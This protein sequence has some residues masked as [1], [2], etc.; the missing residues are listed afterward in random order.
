[1]TTLLYPGLHLVPG[2]VHNT[3]IPK[4]GRI[5]LWGGGGIKVQ[6]VKKALHFYVIISVLLYFCSNY[7]PHKTNIK[8]KY[9]VHLIFWHK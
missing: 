2:V 6:R 8:Y 3:F 9:M 4:I 7:K 1:M 5:S